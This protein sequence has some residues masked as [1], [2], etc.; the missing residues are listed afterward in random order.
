MPRYDSDSESEDNPRRVLD[1]DGDFTLLSAGRS[2]TF[3]LHNFNPMVE[4]KNGNMRPCSVVPSIRPVPSLANVQRARVAMGNG[5]DGVWA[6]TVC[7]PRA[8]PSP[9]AGPSPASIFAPRYINTTTP[10]R[11]LTRF[12]LRRRYVP[13]IGGIKT[14][15]LFTDG[16]CLANG[17]ADARAGWAFISKR[18]GI[19]SG[20]LEQ[21]GPDHEFHTATNNRAELRAVIAALE[22]RAWWV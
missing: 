3:K 4:D 15:L 10:G 22:F 14:M 13:R 7:T 2:F 1:T 21:K 20:V 5:A 18:G 11:T 19:V 8:D 17:A 16:S 6:G 12:V 9:E